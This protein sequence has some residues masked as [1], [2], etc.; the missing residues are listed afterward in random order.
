VNTL[1]FA[2]WSKGV[3]WVA[4]LEEAV[5]EEHYT[6]QDRRVGPEGNRL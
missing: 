6:Q 5:P 3:V 4:H 1:I 2:V